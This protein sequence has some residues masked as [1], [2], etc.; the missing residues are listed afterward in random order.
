[1]RR[2]A[3]TAV[4]RLCLTPRAAA[5][6]ANHK[7]PLEFI[8]VSGEN[9]VGVP[10]ILE[11]LY[12]ARKA[13]ARAGRLPLMSVD[14]VEGGGSLV[15][16]NLPPLKEHQVPA[17]NAFLL[18]GRVASGTL[19]GFPGCGKTLIT[20]HIASHQPGP[21]LVVVPTTIARDQWA[22]TLRKCGVSTH[23]LGQDESFQWGRV[24]VFVA[25]YWLL[26]AQQASLSA[27]VAAL[28]TRALTVSYGSLI[29]D[30]VHKFPAP[31]FSTVCTSVF[32]RCTIGCTATLWRADDRIANGHLDDLI[33]GPVRFCIS[34]DDV[35]RGLFPC[36]EEVTHT[37]EMS[38]TFLAAWH[39]GTHDRRLLGCL[40]PKKLAL[41]AELIACEAKKKATI[42]AIVFCDWVDA[43]PHVASVIRRGVRTSLYGPLSG[44]TPTAV[45]QV[46][47]R[48]FR[49]ATDGV[50]VISRVG[51]M[52][53]NIP[54]AELCLQ[55]THRNSEESK[56]QRR[57]RVLR[58]CEGKRS[59]NIVL[60]TA[61]TPEA[62]SQNVEGTTTNAPPDILVPELPASVECELLRACARPK[63]KPTPREERHG[64]VRRKRKPRLLKPSS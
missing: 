5:L 11:G 33:G 62:L 14:V 21:V 52:A 26:S 15:R 4:D 48:Q 22:D 25:T 6:V 7:V 13:E 47:L 61:G 37:V 60:V 64:P 30:E 27:D 49:C 45:R 28:V 39:A 59:K 55:I 42:K 17:A 19:V 36:V 34:E 51:E 10:E 29:L 56:V 16:A 57:G 1:M 44:G 50:L 8:P 53:L 31:V 63:P 12:Q 24:G 3:A 20:L 18:D 40:N 46:A 38:S 43:L 9:V 41:A 2:T 23:V 58:E 32:R 35:A 54:D